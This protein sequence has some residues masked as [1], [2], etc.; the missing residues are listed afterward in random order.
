MKKGA[1]SSPQPE[2][3]VRVW[4]GP[5]RLLHW[6]LVA[7]VAV[8][9]LTLVDAIGIG[10]WHKPAGY[11]ALAVVLLRV[12]WGVIGTRHARFS[13]FVRGPARTVRYAGDVLGGDEPRHLGHN[14][15]GGW[16]VVALIAAVAS[17]SFTGWLY[18][19][20][21]FFGSE[22]VE[23]SHRWL[24]WTLLAL[25]AL[26]VAGVLYTSLRHRENLVRAM[27]DGMKRAPAAHDIE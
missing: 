12:L 19:T 6:S 10:A 25:V 3:R 22:A 27:V 5:V 14:P 18:T 26:H 15:L 8:T 4:D 20:D 21:A 17:L 16:M 7:S 2:P 24:A 23:D 13:A 1:A 11:V 9:A